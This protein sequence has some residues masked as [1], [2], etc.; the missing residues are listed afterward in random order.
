MVVAMLPMIFT[1]VSAIVTVVDL[2]LKKVGGRRSMVDLPSS[3]QVLLFCNIM[4]GS[5]GLHGGTSARAHTVIC[6]FGGQL[7]RCEFLE[8]LIVSVDHSVIRFVFWTFLF[9]S[10]S[11]VWSA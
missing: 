4:R 2:G 5:R 11:S 7:L 1:W 9:E 6:S 8:F 3:Q 10:D